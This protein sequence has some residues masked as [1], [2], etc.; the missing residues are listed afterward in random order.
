MSAGAFQ[1]SF[2]TSD[3]GD[4]YNIR[5]QPETLAFSAQGTPATAAT[6]EPSAIANGARR[7]IG[8]NARSVRLEWTGTPPTGYD[9]NS[10]VRVPI[11]T[12]AAYTAISKGDTVTYLGAPARV[13][14]KTPEY[15]N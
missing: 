12:L 13:L 15:I 9:A 11:V 2:Y 3:S 1:N 14:G 4:V 10:V 8:V 5:L 7:R 6:A